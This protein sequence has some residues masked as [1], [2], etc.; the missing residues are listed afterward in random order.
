VKV[1]VG[2]DVKVG[3]GA[4]VKVSVGAGV[5]GTAQEARKRIV[6]RNSFVCFIS[7]SFRISFFAERNSA[8]G[9][10]IFVRAP[11][12]AD[13]CCLGALTNG[14]RFTCDAQQSSGSTG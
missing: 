13:Y 9:L 14:L 4:D 8:N 12:P 5:A 7:F 11:L 2:T 6:I 10:H 1:S 3:I